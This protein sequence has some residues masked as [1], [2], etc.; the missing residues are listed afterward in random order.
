MA[1]IVFCAF[2]LEAFLNQ[3]GEEASL[4]GPKDSVGPAEKLRRIAEHRDITIDRSRRPFSSFNLIFRFR[5][6]LAHARNEALDFEPNQ[7]L[8]A[9]ESPKEPST[10][11]ERQCDLRT[12]D[13]YYEDTILIMGALQGL[14]AQGIE[15]AIF[16]DLTLVSIEETSPWGDRSPRLQNPPSRPDQAE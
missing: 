10:W 3:L 1:A 16:G 15:I 12:A 11:W 2:T 14:Q 9:A 13:R 4:W 7:R 6:Q 8:H 5:N